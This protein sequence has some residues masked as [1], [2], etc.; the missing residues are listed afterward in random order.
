MQS[1][2]ATALMGLSG[3]S[4]FLTLLVELE[5]SQTG[6]DLLSAQQFQNLHMVGGSCWFILADLLLI[7][8]FPLFLLLA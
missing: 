8:D 3:I 5:G 1:K 6:Q 2:V 7:A 4:S